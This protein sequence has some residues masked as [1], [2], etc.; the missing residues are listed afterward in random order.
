[1]VLLLTLYATQYNVNTLFQKSE[2][3]AYTHFIKFVPECLHA[4]GGGW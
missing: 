3:A 1:M 4:G 2:A